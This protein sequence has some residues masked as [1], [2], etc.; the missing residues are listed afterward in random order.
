MVAEYFVFYVI[1]K[2]VRISMKI[3]RNNAGMSNDK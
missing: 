2:F 3:I 1:A